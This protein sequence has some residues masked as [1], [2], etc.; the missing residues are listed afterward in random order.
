MTPSPLQGRYM[1][2]FTFP[3]VTNICM[4]ESGRKTLNLLSQHLH[5]LIIT[6]KHATSRQR[7]FR[8]IE[9]RDKHPGEDDST[10]TLHYLSAQVTTGCL[11]C[12][13]ILS[14]PS[15]SLRAI[16]STATCKCRPRWV[17]VTCYNCEGRLGVTL[18]CLHC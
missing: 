5:H 18:P 4:S 13:G 8:V 17:N 1:S 3:F 11:R 7:S 9:K 10:I 15:T 16:V 12:F 2:A 14:D 6:Q